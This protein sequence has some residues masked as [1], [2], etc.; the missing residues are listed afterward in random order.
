MSEIKNNLIKVRERIAQAAKRSGRT[1]E[2]IQLV[3]VS[4]TVPTEKM[5]EAIEAGITDIGENRVQEAVQKHQAIYENE[6]T[7][8]LCKPVKWHLVGHL[9]R[10]KVKPAL[11]IFDMIQSVDSVRLMDA[12]EKRA[13]QMD[14]VVDVLVEVNT[15]S[16]AT[17]YGI[18]PEEIVDFMERASQY[19]YLRVRGLMTIGLFA[20]DPEVTR[21][22]FQQL[23][24]LRD[25]VAKLNLPRIEMKYLSMGMT[26]DFEVAI[27]EGANIVRI[28][29]A[30]FG[31]RTQ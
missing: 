25:K 29:T 11:E 21:P 9:Q 31:P 3:A 24:A 22:C 19:D 4:K 10:N 18:K 8:L 26:N 23:R 16:E 6:A 27:E 14:K 2:S 15:S 7:S 20:D 1:P 28:G 30:I 5:I 12:I 13:A 17:K